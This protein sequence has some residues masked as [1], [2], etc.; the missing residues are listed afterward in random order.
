[1][2]NCIVCGLNGAKILAGMFVGDTPHSAQWCCSAACELTAKRCHRCGGQSAL[3]VSPHPQA[4]EPRIRSWPSLAGTVHCFCSTDCLQKHNVECVAEYAA[5]QR[6]LNA[7][8]KQAPVARSIGNPQP[9]HW[10]TLAAGQLWDWTDVC[11]CRYRYEI[12]RMPRLQLNDLGLM[13]IIERASPVGSACSC[14]TPYKAGQIIHAAENSLFTGTDA[15]HWRRVTAEDLQ[16]EEAGRIAPGQ[17][18]EWSFSS[19]CTRTYEVVDVRN[20]SVRLLAVSHCEGACNCTSIPA[21]IGK[22][23]TGVSLFFPV[24]P[25][26]WRRQGMP[27]PKDWMPKDWIRRPDD[28]PVARPDPDSET[29]RVHTEALDKQLARLTCCIQQ[30]WLDEIGKGGSE[31]AVD[32]AVRL[33]TAAAHWKKRAAREDAETARA[34]ALA[35]RLSVVQGQLDRKRMRV[36]E[37]EDRIAELQAELN[38]LKG[39]R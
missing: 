39:R 14:C 8:A 7:L 17:I 12:L 18:W 37:A 6:T 21:D 13:K 32:V 22:V 1:M 31:G 25:S 16:R 9:D 19:G 26:T 2:S 35:D 24:R 5:E 30:H 34:C 10:R 3:F 36:N 38:R 28:G 11:G 27:K 15:E 29:W 20:Q 23:S 33:L 4:G